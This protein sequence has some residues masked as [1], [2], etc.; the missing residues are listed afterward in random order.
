MVM[1]ELECLQGQRRW[2]V[3][4]ISCINKVSDQWKM[5]ASIQGKERALDKIS[6]ELLMEQN[7]SPDSVGERGR[8]LLPMISASPSLLRYPA[9]A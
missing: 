1:V 3:N 2:A 4:S 8:R 6:E 7:M 9:E 5:L